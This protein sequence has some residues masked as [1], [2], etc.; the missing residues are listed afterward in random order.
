MEEEVVEVLDLEMAWLRNLHDV[1]EDVR[2]DE[3]FLFDFEISLDKLRE[4]FLIY[5]LH[6]SIIS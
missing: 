4:F 5:L 6:F 1:N 2:N 3:I